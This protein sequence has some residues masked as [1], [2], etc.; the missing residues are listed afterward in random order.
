MQDSQ[1]L[2]SPIAD[3]CLL[4]KGQVAIRDKLRYQVESSSLGRP[5]IA[6]PPKIGECR[7]DESN[8]PKLD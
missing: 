1:F 3:Q 7:N 8:I 4:G 6:V 5:R 2:F